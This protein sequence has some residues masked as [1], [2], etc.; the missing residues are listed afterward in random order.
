MNQLTR[1]AGTPYLLRTTSS[2]PGT[3]ILRWCGAVNLQGYAQVFVRCMLRIPLAVKRLRGANAWMCLFD[4]ISP[5]S[6]GIVRHIRSSCAFANAT[7]VHMSSTETQKY[8]S[9]YTFVCL[10]DPF[11]TDASW[12]PW[13]A[14]ANQCAVVGCTQW[15]CMADD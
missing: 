3:F 4:L 7:E 13:S 12:A 11:H 5:C 2:R 6:P 8:I 9:N 15:M 10:R 14:E 1:A